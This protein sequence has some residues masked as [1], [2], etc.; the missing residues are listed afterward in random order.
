MRLLAVLLLVIGC[1]VPS[2][3]DGEAIEW[4]GHWC[5]PSEVTACGQLRIAHGGWCE[6]ITAMSAECVLPCGTTCDD[7]GGICSTEGVCYAR[8]S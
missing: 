2:P 3:L 5:D 8:P 6:P 7:A 1:G 4:F